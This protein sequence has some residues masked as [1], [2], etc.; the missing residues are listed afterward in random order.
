MDFLDHA[1]ADIVV[2]GSGASVHQRTTAP[3]RWGSMSLTPDDLAKA[4]YALLGRELAAPADTHRM[5]PAPHLLAHLW[6]LH[7]T[8]GRLAAS[9]PDVITVYGR[10]FAGLSAI[11][12]RMGPKV[13]GR[14]FPFPKMEFVLGSSRPTAC[15]Q[16][17][18]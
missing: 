17:R 10:H 3:C 4:S 14:K 16:R 6:R 11:C 15:G 12:G 5:R 1:L 18:F 8:A 2:Y 9:A 7:L 13:S